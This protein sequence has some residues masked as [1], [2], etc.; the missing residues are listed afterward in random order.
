MKDTEY[1]KKLIPL[2][3]ELDRLA[4][5]KPYDQEAYNDAVSRCIALQLARYHGRRRRPW[6]ALVFCISLLII[7]V[8]IVYEVL[9]LLY[10]K[11]IQ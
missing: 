7:L 1:F 11:G 9:S 6:A 4:N 5:S 3:D 8:W 2:C 10:T